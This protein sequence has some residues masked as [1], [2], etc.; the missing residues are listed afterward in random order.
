MVIIWEVSMILFLYIYIV[1]I[2]MKYNV[3]IVFISFDIDLYE[4][5]G[6]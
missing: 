6:K 5:L 3:N 4:W 1:R 2:W